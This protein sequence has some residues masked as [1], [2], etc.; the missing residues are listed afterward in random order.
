MR[1]EEI[2]TKPWIGEAKTTDG[3]CPVRFAGDP[4]PVYPNIQSKEYNVDEMG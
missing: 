1:E 2:L 4:F 3:V